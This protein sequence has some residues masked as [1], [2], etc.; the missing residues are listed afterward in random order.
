MAKK[1]EPPK[2]PEE[3]VAR[4]VLALE[5]IAQCLHEITKKGSAGGGGLADLFDLLRQ[6][7]SRR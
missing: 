7:G 5:T 4:I 1:W 6:V 3:S 2:S